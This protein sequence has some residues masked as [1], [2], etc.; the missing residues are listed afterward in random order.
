MENEDSGSMPVGP[1]GWPIVGNTFQINPYKFHFTLEQ[2][3][4][5]FGPTLKCSILRTNMVVLSSPELIRKAF[6]SEKYDKILNDRP[7]S[8]LGKYIMRNYSS[9]IVA[10][11]DETLFKARKT[12]HRALHLYGDGFPKFENTVMGEIDNLIVHLKSYKDNDFDPAPVFERSLGNLVSILVAGEPM[13]GYDETIIWDFVKVSTESLNPAVEFLLFN[14]PILRY[15]PC[16]YRDIYLDLDKKTNALIERYL[17]QYKT[18]YKPGLER[19]IIDGFLRIQREE[20]KRGSTW[21]NDDW[22]IGLLT[23][24]IGG[25]LLTT[26]SARSHYSNRNLTEFNH[27]KLK[28]NLYKTLFWTS[29]TI[30]SYR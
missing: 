2:W 11:Y 8:F 15:I 28:L 16:R 3:V 1:T 30:Y 22:V 27:F 4:K 24:A 6:S 7:E 10:R 19:G 9:M 17:T 23:A 18:T 25:A 26:I 14:F 12:F 5:E 20:M 29:N 13:S 21:L